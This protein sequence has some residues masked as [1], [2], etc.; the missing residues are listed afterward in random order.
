LQILPTS[1]LASSRETKLLISASVLIESMTF[2]VIMPVIRMSNPAFSSVTNGLI[3]RL[4]NGLMYRF[5]FTMGKFAT[6]SRKSRCE[7]P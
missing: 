5:A 2:S 1:L 4:L 6:F 3:S 7:R